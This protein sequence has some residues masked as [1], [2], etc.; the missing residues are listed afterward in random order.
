MTTVLR[1]FDGYPHTSPDL[2]DEVLRAQTLLQDAG[3]EV[4]PDG[5]FGEGTE[6]AVVRFQQKRGLLADG[7]IGPITWAA[8]DG[9]VWHGDMEF[10]TAREKNDGV[11]SAHAREAAKYWDAIGNASMEYRVPQC[12]IA[13]VGSRESGWGMALR[14]PGPGG[15]GDFVPRKG[16]LPVDGQGYGRGL[17]QIDFSAHEFARTGQW[18]DPALNIEYGAKTL[19]GNIKFFQ[20]RGNAPAHV[21]RLAI[22][23]YNCGARNVTRALGA[24]LDIDYYTAHRDYS[25]DVLSRSGWFYAQGWR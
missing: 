5:Y 15:T 24:G 20:G 10:P 21:L 17:M 12:V 7:I 11:L 9:K 3:E 2:R 8:L 1:L 19:A 22:A 4:D 16:G 18:R 14:P 13:G 23:A 25:A 6:A